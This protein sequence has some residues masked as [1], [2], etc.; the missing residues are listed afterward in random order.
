MIGEKEL[1][2]CKKGVRV[3]NAA[4]GGLIDEK[5]LYD[6]IKEGIV[7]SAGIDVL[8]PE[9]SYTKKPEEQDYKHPLLE[10]DNVIFTP[11][12]GASTEEANYNV[13]VDIAKF[14]ASALQGNMVPAVNMPALKSGNMD[15]LK[16]YIEIGEILGKLY[17][18]TEKETVQKLEIIYSGEVA[19]MDTKIVTLSVI[20]GFLSPTTTEKIN[21]VNA[22]MF[23]ENTGVELVES[24]STGHER[25]TNLI[26]VKFITKNKVYAVSGTAFTKDEI[27][28]VDYYN[29]KLNFEPSP[30]FLVL[31]NID[32]PGIIGQVGTMLGASEV[33]V[34]SFQL[35]RNRKGEMAVSF[36]S[37][38][39][40]V[41]QDVLHLLRNIEGVTKVSY[42]SL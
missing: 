36:I 33:N 23:L 12:L 42:V 13:G 9:P 22:P 40:S 11:H 41:P 26:T 29:Y 14:V 10:L 16:P 8:D 24:K 30:H 37:V 25:Y 32:K 35:G 18:Q 2:L 34:A 6:A 31:E 28:V 4:R 38:D 39:G 27:R 20:K 15:D 17:Y 3:V 1:A 19:D 21:F 5:A 7:A